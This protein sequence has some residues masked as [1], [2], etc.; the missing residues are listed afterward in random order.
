MDEVLP[1]FMHGLSLV[2][3]RAGF[4]FHC[5]SFDWANVVLGLFFIDS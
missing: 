2:H 5:V 4:G 3:Y 1:S